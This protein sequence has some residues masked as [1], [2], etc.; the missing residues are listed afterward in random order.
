MGASVLNSA[1]VILSAIFFISG[2]CTKMA[3]PFVTTAIMPIK[4]AGYLNR[5]GYVQKAQIMAKDKEMLKE[6]FTMVTVT[7]LQLES[8][9]V[10]TSLK[11]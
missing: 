10:R 5:R 1:I 3:S 11:M 7:L 2:V 6:K 9:S 4:I 8:F